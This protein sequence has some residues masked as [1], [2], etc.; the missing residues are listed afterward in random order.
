MQRNFPDSGNFNAT[1]YASTVTRHYSD[2][3]SSKGS[4][5]IWCLKE[6][7]YFLLLRKFIVWF[8]ILIIRYDSDQ[9][10]MLPYYWAIFIGCIDLGVPRY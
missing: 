3:K 10:Q 1:T 6:S 4:K 2:V 7:L 9:I 5:F 8:D